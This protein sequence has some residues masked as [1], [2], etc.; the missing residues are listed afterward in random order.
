M[1]ARERLAAYA[2]PMV[3]VR[4]QKVTIPTTGRIN[5]PEMLERFEKSINAVAYDMALALASKEPGILTPEQLLTRIDE[6]FPECLKLTSA[7]YASE[8]KPSTGTVHPL[9]L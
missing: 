2:L 1:G 5:M 3:S 6:L 8:K 9:R 4:S 7:K